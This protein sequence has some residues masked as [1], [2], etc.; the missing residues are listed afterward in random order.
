MRVDVGFS[1][2]VLV[3]L[4]CQTISC[5]IA[6]VSSDVCTSNGAGCKTTSAVIACLKEKAVP[7]K[8]QLA[9]LL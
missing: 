2:N 9:V 3:T 1:D 6:Q 7:K 4:T 5:S 8:S